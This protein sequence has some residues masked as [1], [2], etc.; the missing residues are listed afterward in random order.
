MMRGVQTDV[1][2]PLAPA[3]TRASLVIAGIIFLAVLAAL[4][5]AV[6][7][8]GRVG[9]DPPPAAPAF[10]PP[11]AASLPRFE[12]RSVSGGSA[13]LVADAARGQ[14]AEATRPLDLAN[15]TI[16]L[17]RPISPSDI[18]PGDRVTVIGVFNPVRNFAV[19]AVVVMTGGGTE[20]E[21]PVSS[22]GFLG[23]EASKDSVERPLLA[24]T[25][26]ALEPYESTIEQVDSQG[27]ANPARMAGQR[28]TLDRKPVPFRLDLLEGSRTYRL[29]PG[30]AAAIAP[31]GRVALRE[32][33]GRTAVLVLPAAVQP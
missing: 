16:E 23:F 28:L 13:L 10:E 6:Y 20:G 26:L 33:G 12:V 14:S 30:S 5:T 25:V 11:V 1:P 32:G 7:L 27:K 2:A 15:A 18:R 29:E 21:F 19:R 3:D 9:D 4:A 17:L 8:S 24:G 31:G 22:G